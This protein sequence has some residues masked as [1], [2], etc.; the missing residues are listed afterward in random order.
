MAN[1][2]LEILKT[3]HPRLY[4]N[5][6]RLNDL[7]ELQEKD[8]F[9]QLLKEGLIRKADR[10][11]HEKPVEFKITGPRMLK[12]CQEILS[13]VSSL[14]LTCHLTKDLQYAMRAK[15]ELVSAAS[16]PHWN[17]DH[18]LDTAELISAFSIGYDWLFH[19]LSKTDLSVIR[20]ALIDKGLKA[21]LEEHKNNVWWASHKYN[22]NQVCNGAL[23]IGALAIGDEEPQLANEIFSA[24]SRHLPLAF[25]SYGKDGGWEAGPD[26]W[27]YTTWYSALLIDALK[28]VTGND[29]GLSDTKG[30][31][32]TGL[33]PIYMAGPNDR[34]FN[35]A[36]SDEAYK[37][38]PVLYWLGKKFNTDACIFE[39]HRLLRK[40]LRKGKEIDAFNLVWYQPAPERTPLLP[41]ARCF[42]D[43]NVVST[44]SEWANERA[45]FIACKG[46]NNQ[47][48]HA[49]L[50]SGSFVLDMNG[51]R[52]ASDLGRDSYDLPGYFD[53]SEGGER[54]KYFRLNTQ[55]HNTLVLNNDNQRAAA[56]SEF[57][58][59]HFTTKE[60]FVII[61]LSEAYIPH[62]TSVLRT[63]KMIN[64]NE[65]RL[66]DFIR[67]AGSQ[68][69][70]Q[71]QMLT[72]AEVI[73][74]GRKAELRKG[75]KKIYAAILQPEDVVFEV[76]PAER[77][78][79]ENLNQGFRQLIMRKTEKNSST[80]I[81]ISFS[82]NPLL[83]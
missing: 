62:A 12:N 38:L 42:S 46:G 74:S 30:F 23:M 47:A 72:D 54:W 39:N 22:W 20:H 28:E 14:A 13:R 16:Y 4:I 60:S 67:W 40:S 51:E 15:E 53:L 43:I 83:I 9:F 18:F 58:K 75:G 36:D 2:K 63:I 64:N 21:G 61:D 41:A 78:E 10:I 73:L 45:L 52:W 11:M 66:E 76:I 82:N 55:S 77:T 31:E 29:L 35:F 56:K 37:P 59:T 6:K 33:F 25:N 65:I 7:A 26:Y 71:W 24:T 81:I 50:D 44:R 49:H 80:G 8:I 1:N 79:P 5:P 32:K 27:E 19:I 68:K 48:D 70:I 17:K 69:F 3:G 57:I 34:Y